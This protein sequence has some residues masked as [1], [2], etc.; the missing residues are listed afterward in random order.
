M[1]SKGD[2]HEDLTEAFETKWQLVG[3][4]LACNTRIQG[5]QIDYDK[6]QL[7]NEKGQMMS[8]L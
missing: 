1:C 4:S 7:P 3:T 2:L 8:K 6:G 5:F